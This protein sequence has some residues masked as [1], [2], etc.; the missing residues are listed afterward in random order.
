MDRRGDGQAR[1]DP[2]RL[3]L[4]IRSDAGASSGLA[5]VANTPDQTTIGTNS[6]LSAT[7]PG[8]VAASALT[9][10]VTSVNSTSASVA[11]LST[12]RLLLPL[13]STISAGAITTPCT[14]NA[15]GTFTGT[16]T[17]ASLGILGASYSGTT[18]T[19]VPPAAVRTP[20]VFRLPRARAWR[21]A[22]ASSAW[23]AR[24]WARSTS[25][26]MAWLSPTNSP[27]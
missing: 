19:E 26:A 17:V 13:L 25:A 14:A 16:T 7:V 27:G 21:L 24:A 1:G 15:D 8:I 6:A 3:G 5:S 20:L 23:P 12:A 22:L 10:T 11:N 2:F 4:I 9:A 18:T